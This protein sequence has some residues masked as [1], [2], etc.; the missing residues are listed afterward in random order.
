MPKGSDRNEEL[1]RRLRLWERG[2]KDDLV[3]HVA[4]QQVCS[5]VPST[6]SRPEDR[7]SEDDDERLCKRARE[8]TAIGTRSKAMKGLVGGVANGSAE[9]KRQ[10]TESL[11][12]RSS[13]VT[14][15]HQDHAEIAAARM[16][17]WGK[18]DA[19]A[20]KAAMREVGRKLDK[21]PSPT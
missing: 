20:A 7:T 1:K 12:P 16:Q 10:W 6:P 3:Q 4:C 9:E 21:L 19:N 2:E 18:G 13:D 8:Q 11:I 14:I 5:D 17:A 15:A